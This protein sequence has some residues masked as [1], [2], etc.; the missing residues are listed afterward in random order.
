MLK[1]LLSFL[2]NKCKTFT[3][4]R[5][6]SNKK[7]NSAIIFAIIHSLAGAL[8]VTYDQCIILICMADAGQQHRWQRA[9]NLF[10]LITSTHQ[11]GRCDLWCVDHLFITKYGAPHLLI[12]FESKEYEHIQ[13]LHHFIS[14]SYPYFMQI[15]VIRQ[16][17]S[18]GIY[19]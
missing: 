1:R 16:G 2:L 12:V 17:W 7:I 9:R 14:R 19:V 11:L 15:F 13:F 4:Y 18:K 6:W 5:I 8:G 3:I 10:F